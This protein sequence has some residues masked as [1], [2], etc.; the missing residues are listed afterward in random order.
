VRRG[1]TLQ[2]VALIF[3]SYTEPKRPLIIPR[4]F[5]VPWSI[6]FCNF[7]GRPDY[8]IFVVNKMVPYTRVSFINDDMCSKLKA[9]VQQF[10][11]THKT[12]A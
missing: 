6:F 8:F 7:K 2:K 12:N 3:Y 10:R 11:H 1:H 9:C 4:K 5:R